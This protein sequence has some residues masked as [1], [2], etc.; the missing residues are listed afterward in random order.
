M[1]VQHWDCDFSKP[2]PKW[3]DVLKTAMETQPR[4]IKGK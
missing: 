2:V 3:K 1:N 4:E